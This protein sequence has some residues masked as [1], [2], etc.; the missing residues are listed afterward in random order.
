MA[1][2]LLTITEAA[3][4]LRISRNTALRLIESGELPHVKIH[5]S[6]CVRLKAV[7]AFIREHEKEGI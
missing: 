2:Q 4:R 7:S 1:E 5:R 6:V 3:K